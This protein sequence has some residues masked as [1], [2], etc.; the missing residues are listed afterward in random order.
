M[1]AILK[2]VVPSIFKVLVKI[3]SYEPRTELKFTLARYI[4]DLV[5]DVGGKGYWYK[6]LNV[7]E[8]TIL[9]SSIFIQHVLKTYVY[10]SYIEPLSSTMQVW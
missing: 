8:Q 3:E 2:L 4:Y 9:P 10:F 5:S 6:T 7:M 1:V